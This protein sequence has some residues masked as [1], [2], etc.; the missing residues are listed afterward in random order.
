M[1]LSDLFA[2]DRPIIAPIALLPLPGSPRYGGRFDEVLETALEDAR[3]LESGG[4]DGL[5]LEN[6]GDAPYFKTDVPPETVAAMV[7]VLT[8]LRR[9]TALPI[10]VN[11][12][13]NAGRA[14]LA[15]AQG[16]GGSFVRVNV[17][18]EAYVTDQGIVEGIAAELMRARRLMGAE[19]IAVFADVHVKH[20]AP[21][22]QRPIRESAQDLVERGLAD[23]LVVSGSRTGEPPSVDDLRSVRDV[24]SVVIGSGVTADNAEE[25]LPAADGAIV[26]TAFR[27]DGD[28]RKRV[29][30]ERVERIV[31]IAGRLRAG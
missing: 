7:R 1:K 20:A 27:V 23:V 9:R 18:T 5:S 8:E 11:V 26:A 28:V 15:V 14:S 21:L 22:L 12:L 24:A 13:R 17:L 29:D 6:L 10:G 16:G 31:S 3:V 19:G 30:P 2:V 4:V 25:L